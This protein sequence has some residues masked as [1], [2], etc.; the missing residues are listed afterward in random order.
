MNFFYIEP[1]VAGELGPTTVV[2]NSMHPPVVNLLEY[3]FES[4]LGDSILES[5]PCFVVTRPLADALTTNKFSGFTID[6]VMISI[7]D[8]FKELQP[9]INLPNFVWL[10]ITGQSGRD[11]FGLADDFRLVVSDNV[12]HVLKSFNLDNAD[13]EDF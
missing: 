11:D 4:W 3:R 5:F 2:D 6:S 1:E 7:S 8:E 12:L 10:K 9:G 13:I